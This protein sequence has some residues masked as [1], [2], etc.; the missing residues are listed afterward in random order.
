MEP[1]ISV[2][3]TSYNHEP[4]IEK[5]LA[6]V[7]EQVDC[8]EFEI[9]IG[10]D[11]SQDHTPDIIEKYRKQHPDKIRV[12]SRNKNL[13]LQQNMK[14]CFYSCRG[15]YIAICEG[16]DFWIDPHKLKIQYEA[17]ASHSDAVLCFNDI[18]LLK[19]TG[20]IDHIPNVKAKFTDRINASDLIKTRNMIGNFSCCMYRRDV[21]KA[22]PD[23]FWKNNRTVDFTFNLLALTASPYALYI[24]KKMSVYRILNN[25]LSHRDNKYTKFANMI[26]MLSYTQV[27]TNF[28]HMQLIDD[29]ISALKEQMEKDVSKEKKTPAA[30][31][32]QPA[33]PTSEKPGFRKLFGLSFKFRNKRFLIG[34]GQK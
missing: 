2:I 26:K 18:H 5:S 10:D 20:T 29:W 23:S 12:L 9:V 34:I 24:N 15:T 19:N 25:S 6:G 8:P 27:M 14:D 1:V 22:I 30:A 31:A 4:Y 17:L 32:S 28:A 7:L 13:G 16:D 33:A 3:I 11:C 21:L